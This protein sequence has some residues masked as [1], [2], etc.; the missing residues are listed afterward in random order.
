MFPET[1]SNKNKLWIDIKEN[2]VYFNFYFLH[3]VLTA[4]LT[5]FFPES[6]TFMYAYL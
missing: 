4:C 2:F 1:Q 6:A 3:M 5:E